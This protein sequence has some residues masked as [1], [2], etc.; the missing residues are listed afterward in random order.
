LLLVFR[1]GAGYLLS[2]RVTEKQGKVMSRMDL[3]K[4]QDIVNG[5]LAM[6]FAHT[7]WLA[8]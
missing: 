3:S 8:L 2:L 7:N 6:V 4:I 1:T 5:S